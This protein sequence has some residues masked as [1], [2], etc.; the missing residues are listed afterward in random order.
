LGAADVSSARTP[1]AK[2]TGSTVEA[3]RVTRQDSERLF[4]IG[5]WMECEREADQ[6]LR[7]ITGID[8]DPLTPP[9]GDQE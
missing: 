2:R 3:I 6:M 8:D 9:R 4:D 7:T 5:F 1:G